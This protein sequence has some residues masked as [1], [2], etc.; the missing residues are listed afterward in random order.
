MVEMVQVGRRSLDMHRDDQKLSER[1]YTVMTLVK[2]ES[3]IN[4]FGHFITAS[5][6][7]PLFLCFPA[8]QLAQ[9]NAAC[10]FFL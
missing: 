5:V 10:H 8:F 6:S 2:N 1:S 9:R 7:S 4:E 3:L